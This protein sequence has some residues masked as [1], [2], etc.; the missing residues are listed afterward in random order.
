MLLCV[1]AGCAATLWR[2][3][4]RRTCVGW[5][6]DRHR[7]ALRYGSAAPGGRSAAVDR[8]SPHPVANIIGLLSTPPRA[9]N[10]LSTVYTIHPLFMLPSIIH[11]GDITNNNTTILCFHCE[12]L[13][14]IAL[15]TETKQIFPGGATGTQEQDRIPS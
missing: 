15:V 11:H 14:C 8:R 5:E 7:F 6:L 4:G 2:R 9:D 10:F 1:L 12:V 3:D 13:E